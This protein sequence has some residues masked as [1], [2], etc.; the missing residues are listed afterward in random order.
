MVAVLALLAPAY[1]AI[2]WQT[3]LAST[4]HPVERSYAVAAYWSWREYCRWHDRFNQNAY[5]TEL[6]VVL[7][8]ATRFDR[9][10][11]LLINAV[12]AALKQ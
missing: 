3:I 4:R 11:E 7:D 2:D 8:C 12:K 1:G 5:K 10:N 9:Q 6:R